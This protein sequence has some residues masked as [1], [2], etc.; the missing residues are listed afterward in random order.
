MERFIDNLSKQLART[1][2]RRSMLSI[3]A[4]TLFASFV[5]STWIGR[6][7]AQAAG[8]P[9]DV[10]N[11]SCGAL[12]QAV[13]LA[14]PDPTRYKNHGAYVSSVAHSVSAAQNASLITDACSG[15]IVSQFAQ[16]VPL[17]QQ[18]SCGTIVEPTQ[19]CSST[20]IATLQIQTATVLSLAA[21]PNAWS[22]PSQWVLLIQLTEAILGCQISS[23]N[24]EVSSSIASVAVTQNQATSCLSPRVNYCG[25]DNSIQN[26][27][28]SRVAYAPCLNAA[29]FQHD[30]CYGEQCPPITRECDF[31]A[32]TSQCDS[33]LVATCLGIGN[34]TQ[35]ELDDPSTVLEN[36]LVCTIVQCLTA[37]ALPSAL[38]GI[39]I[40]QNLFRSV[41]PECSETTSQCLDCTGTGEACGSICCPCGQS[42]ANGSCQCG[43]GLTACG[44]NCCTGLQQCCPSTSIEV[45]P[46]CCE[47]GDIC[48]GTTCCTF[49]ERCSNGSCVP[50]NPADGD[51]PC[52]ITC[53]PSG[54]RCLNGSCVT[55]CPSGETPCGTICCPFGETCSNGSC[56][57]A[58]YTYSISAAFADGS[59]LS[60]TFTYGDGE[61]VTITATAFMPGNPA[62]NNL[63][64]VVT[65][66]GNLG[67]SS[68]PHLG[69]YFLY[70]GAPSSSLISGGGPICTGQ[71]ISGPACFTEMGLRDEIGALYY[72]LAISGQVKLLAVSPS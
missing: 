23:S 66:D 34:C 60:G 51:T 56:V 52:G 4:R 30:N 14:F 62:T 19:N 59:T 35:A 63:P 7:W 1:T 40:T 57:L 54:Q 8:S 53:C 48:C 10:G 67:T 11:S 2:S 24:G 42:C 18:Q 25:P 45:L 71:S 16:S 32:Q 44:T 70:P 72:T 15:C 65:F 55:N 27:V 69:N 39:C 38:N 17:D 68:T 22:D 58:V 5:S 36:F 12:Q 9:G 46:H 6:L 13:Q 21:A 47:G 31:T 29:C 49:G 61:I 26:P 41:L 33:P 3:T 28:L 50:C 43:P 20:G 37:I 64:S